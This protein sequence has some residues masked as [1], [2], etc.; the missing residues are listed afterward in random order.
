RD[1]GYGYAEA[2][3]AAASYAA[4]LGPRD[5]EGAYKPYTTRE[6]FASVDQA[7][8]R[9]TPGRPNATSR[10]T[11]TA[12]PV[13]SIVAEPVQWLWEGRIPVRAIT[14]LVG[15]PGLGKSLL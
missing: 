6:A 9:A 1:A 15:D 14:L 12:V 2:R 3:A 8:S 10:A 7:Y 4:S 11:L 5:L 13:S